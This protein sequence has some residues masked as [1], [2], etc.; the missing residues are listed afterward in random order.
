MNTY[1]SQQTRLAGSWPFPAA[2]APEGWGEAQD[3]FFSLCP[4]R[5]LAFAWCPSEE[6]SGM[7]IWPRV[8]AT[9]SILQG[10]TK[11]RVRGERKKQ[12]NQS[13]STVHYSSLKWHAHL[14]ATPAPVLNE[15]L[16]SKRHFNQDRKALLAFL[17]IWNN[18]HTCY[19]SRQTHVSDEL[20][21]L[22]FFF[23]STS[24]NTGKKCIS[25][26][27][28][29]RNKWSDLCSPWTQSD[30]KQNPQFLKS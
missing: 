20:S 6:W 15:G 10:I 14:S 9:T 8:A 22:L 21:Q 24:Q 17:T 7:E 28:F 12:E 27:Y 11:V 3:R 29:L 19:S 5:A 26:S 1:A 4:R 2:F 23:D 13:S 18:C 16:Q 25:E 30:F